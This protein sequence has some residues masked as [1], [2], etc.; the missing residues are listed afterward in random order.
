MGTIPNEVAFPKYEPFPEGTFKGSLAGASVTSGEGGTW[1][2]LDV[3]FTD[4]KSLNGSI[5]VGKRP[6]KGNIPI[7]VRGT[8]LLEIDDW[9]TLPDALFPLVVAAR[10]L[11]GMALAFGAA[12][13]TEDGVD[14]DLDSFITDLEDGAYENY[15]TVFVT[16]HRERQVLT[17]SGEPALDENGEVIKR[18]DANITFASPISLRV[19]G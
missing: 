5:D 11:A 6:Y 8:S 13:K 14:V 12:E 15:E 3:T 9:T 17:P 7:K 19:G 4:V 18:V 16:R 10:V 1:A 2:R